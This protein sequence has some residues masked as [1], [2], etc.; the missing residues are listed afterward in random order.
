MKR[1]IK[2]FAL[3]KKSLIQ[4]FTKYDGED[5]MAE[6]LVLARESGTE[7]TK[8]IAKKMSREL[9]EQWQTSGESNRSVFKL[10]KIHDKALLSRN[11]GSPKL[12]MLYDFIELEN[13]KSSGEDKF[14]LLIDESKSNPS[15]SES[16]VRIVEKLV[17]EYFNTLLSR[18]NFNEDDLLTRLKLKEE[19]VDGPTF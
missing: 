7:R 2:L 13:G 5:F 15:L 4:A 18:N 17:T 16:E 12:E 8:Y 14:A 10:L 19:G 3:Q 9:M 11:I 6:A 1:L